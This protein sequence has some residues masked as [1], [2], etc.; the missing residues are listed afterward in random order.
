VFV[1]HAPPF[2]Y[3]AEAV[4]TDDEFHKG[5]ECFTSFDVT[6]MPKYHL[7][8]HLHLNGSPVSREAVELFGATTY[9]NSTGYRIIEL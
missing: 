7:F 3:G 5:F 9:V 4:N 2:G 1:T 6:Y 8:G